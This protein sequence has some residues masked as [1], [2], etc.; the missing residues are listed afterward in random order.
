MR[1]LPQAATFAAAILAFTVM[2]SAISS[3]EDGYELTVIRPDASDGV[4]V[5]RINVETG[6]VSN[7]TGA[8]AADVAES[9]PLPAG[10][11][12]LYSAQTPD[13]K[14]YWL[15]RLDT[16]SGRTWFFSNNAWNEVVQGK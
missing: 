4:T 12:R 10:E 3:A 2:G 6:L 15:Y 5:Y 9:Q 8:T 11:Y 13:K 16:R 14:S 7:V 1:Y